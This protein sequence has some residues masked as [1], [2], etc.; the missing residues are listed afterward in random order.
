MPHSTSAPRLG[1]LERVVMEHLWEAANVGGPLFDGATV[2]EVHL[3]FEGERVASFVTSFNGGD[4]A[5]YRIVGSKGDIHV[6]PAYEYAESL[7]YTLTVD[8]TPQRK[9]IGKRDQFAPELLHFSDCIRHDR[10][11]EPSGEEG[12]A[13]VRIVQA[14]Y[15]SA[16]SG[17]WEPVELDWRG[18]TTARIEA[19]GELFEGSTVIKREVLPDGRVKLILKDPSGDY[20]DRVIAGG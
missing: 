17:Q 10:T 11:P 13:D 1:D 16:K 15:R 4:V 12:L 3:R 19:K 8:G 5:E 14:L 6:D 2:R 7:G 18:G 20:V 9:T